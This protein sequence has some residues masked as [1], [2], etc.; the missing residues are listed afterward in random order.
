MNIETRWERIKFGPRKQHVPCRVGYRG[1]CA[2]RQH[3][4][5]FMGSSLFPNLLFD[6]LRLLGVCRRAVCAGSGTTNV[7]F[8]TVYPYHTWGRR[9]AFIFAICVRVCTTAAEW[10]VAPARPLPRQSN[11]L[12]GIKLFIICSC[13]KRNYIY[14]KI[15]NCLLHQPIEEG[16]ELGMQVGGIISSASKMYCSV[17]HITM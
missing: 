1:W 12:H 13:T 10:R 11:H 17:D 7:A 9:G 16:G 5:I 6:F 14:T 2:F 8:V 15:I 4:C 3:N